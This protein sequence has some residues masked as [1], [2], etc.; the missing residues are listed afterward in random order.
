MN[1]TSVGLVQGC[2]ACLD[3][4]RAT[5]SV[6]WRTNDNIDSDHDE[7]FQVRLLN[8]AVQLCYVSIRYMSP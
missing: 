5:S 6:Y 3:Q 1:D 4:M 7:D 8:K 2:G